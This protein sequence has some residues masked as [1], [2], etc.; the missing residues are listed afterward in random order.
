MNSSVT[1][2]LFLDRFYGRKKRIG[3]LND[4]PR[5][6]LA[7]P[8][9]PVALYSSLRSFAALLWSPNIFELRQRYFITDIVE[10]KL[11]WHTDA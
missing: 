2:A 8:G 3:I 5:R 6:E 9:R 7:P 4:W 11:D 1:P 10:P